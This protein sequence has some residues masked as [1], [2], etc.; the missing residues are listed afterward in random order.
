[1]KTVEEYAIDMVA[2]GAESLIEDDLNEDDE[3]S[4]EDHKAAVD[5]ALAMVR[6]IREFPDVVI[7]MARRE[8]ITIRLAELPDYGLT[9]A[10]QIRLGVTKAAMG[11]D[12][13]VTEIGAEVNFARELA[14]MVAPI[15]A[16]V[17]TGVV[18]PAPPLAV[19]EVAATP[20]AG[21]DPYT[22]DTEGQY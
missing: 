13:W 6:A 5:L 1:M 11:W 22:S 4:D 7:A 20:A 18:E 21:Q 2:A 3:I 10:Q 14:A 17:E 19:D 15:A 16:Y 8:Q 9:A 12:C